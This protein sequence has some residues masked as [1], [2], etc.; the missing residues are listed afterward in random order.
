MV[1][2]KLVTMDYADKKS[3]HLTKETD[4][5]VRSYVTS[6]TR[7][8]SSGGGHSGGG[9]SSSHGSSGGGHSSGSG[10]HF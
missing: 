2:K 3:F 8:S 6:H 1:K 4:R 7:T 5:F 9:Y 10:G